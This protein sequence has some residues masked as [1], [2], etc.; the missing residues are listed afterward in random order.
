[1]TQDALAK[2]FELNKAVWKELTDNGFDARQKVDLD[3]YFTATDPQQALALC[4]HLVEHEGYQAAA[5]E[6]RDNNHARYV[7]QVQWK[8]VQISREWTDQMVERWI[9]LAAPFRCEF[10]GWGIAWK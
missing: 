8:A 10:G 7:V 6:T 5:H 9:R 4:K 3:C 1:M 2:H